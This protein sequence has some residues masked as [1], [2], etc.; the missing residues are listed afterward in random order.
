MG[1]EKHDTIHVIKRENN[2]TPRYISTE[3]KFHLFHAPFRPSVGGLYRIFYWDA[4]V[5]PILLLIL[6]LI[7]D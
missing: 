5:V 1:K 3:R 2:G 4:P 6:L 7:M